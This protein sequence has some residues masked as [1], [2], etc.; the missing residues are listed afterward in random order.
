MASKTIRKPIPKAHDNNDAVGRYLRRR[1]QV[2]SGR[3]VF[4]SNV[5]KRVLIKALDKSYKRK[6]TS[7]DAR[8]LYWR[9]K[10]QYAIKHVRK[11]V[12]ALRVI[13][14]V[15]GGEFTTESLEP[16]LLRQMI[17]E[18]S[19]STWAATYAR[20]QK[21]ITPK[22]DV[23]NK[24]QHLNTTL[25]DGQIDKE[26]HRN[27]FN[28][29]GFEFD[30][31]KIPS[32]YEK[33]IETAPSFRTELQLMHLADY[34]KTFAYFDG[35][36][37]GII[38]EFA[39][40][41]HMARK[42]AG[43]PVYKAGDIAENFYIVLAGKLI[44]MI[45]QMNIDFVVA[46]IE[47]GGQFGEHDLTQHSH[48][49]T[50][51]EIENNKT[52]VDQI[53]SANAVDTAV[54]T[55]EMNVKKSVGSNQNEDEV[56]G[57][58]RDK[59]A[60]QN[61]QVDVID[62]IEDANDDA[63]DLTVSRRTHDIV[64]LTPVLCLRVSKAEY[65]PIYNEVLKRDLNKKITTLKSIALFNLCTEEEINR[66]AKSAEIRR[67]KEQSIIAKEGHL[68]QFLYIVCDGD[69]RSL[70]KV[71]NDN[72]TIE[73]SGR[74]ARRN[75]LVEIQELGEGM[76]FGETVLFDDPP[77]KDINGRRKYL[78][79]LKYPGSLVSNAY[80]EIMVIPRRVFDTNSKNRKISEHAVELIRSTAAQTK[81]L[82]AKPVIE[83]KLQQDNIWRRKRS[84][85]LLP[86]LSDTQFKL[87]KMNDKFN[88]GYD[89]VL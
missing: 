13:R 60:I 68:A 82:Y 44:I 78:P 87:M 76:T 31:L 28:N 3:A 69:C 39:S 26:R 14:R 5:L 21:L 52:K 58:I 23:S 70:M 19:Y 75:L 55:N 15:K 30:N 88:Q 85:V 59:N 8:H 47:A 18:F 56:A 9:R 40:V 73:A 32:V 48:V 37:M 65:F 80:A 16:N 42:P 72:N 89:Q 51:Q 10:W 64:T 84:K 2:R 36:P 20:Q 45:R 1:S 24:Q 86:L 25:I 33:I 57:A 46:K 35:M 61:A 49:E 74:R 43:V 77:T 11:A 6:E 54:V 79:R 83:H 71:K 81:L 38:L 41:V 27:R 4:K 62:E 29:V 12:K 7:D 34:L 53:V 67:Y 63:Q 22:P 50:I 66:L 17:S